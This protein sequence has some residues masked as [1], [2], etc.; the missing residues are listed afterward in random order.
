MQ[1]TWRLIGEFSIIGKGNA[2]EY[3]DGQVFSTDITPLLQFKHTDLYRAEKLQSKEVWEEGDLDGQP[4]EGKVSGNSVRLKWPE[5]HPK[6]SYSFIP[7]K[8]YL[9][10]LRP[11]V[12]FDSGEFLGYVSRE[13]LPLVD[14]QVVTGSMLDWL[15]YKITLKKID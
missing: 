9:G 7:R 5:F 11:R 12:D 8:S 3:Y 10:Q 13:D 14:G 1:Y 6:E 4:I 15:K 2:R